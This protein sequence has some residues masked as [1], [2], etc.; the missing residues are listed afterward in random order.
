MVA[1]P[2]GHRFPLGATMFSAV[3]RSQGENPVHLWTCDDGVLESCPRWR[4][5]IWRPGMACGSGGGGLVGGI[6]CVLQGV[7]TVRVSRN[8]QRAHG[9]WRT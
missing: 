6:A 8:V 5:R 2:L 3:W 4:R 7:Y 9:Y 1:A